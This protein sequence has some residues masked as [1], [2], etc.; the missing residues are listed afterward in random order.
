MM[1][2]HQYVPDYFEKEVIIPILKDVDGNSNSSDNYRGIILS[3]AV[4]KL[5]ELCFFY[6]FSTFLYSSNLHLVS[7]KKL[8]VT[9]HYFA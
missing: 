1:F 4:S 5:F 8:A 3:P 7:R 9:I 6:K 2:K